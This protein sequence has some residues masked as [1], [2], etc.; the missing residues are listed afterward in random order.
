MQRGNQILPAYRVNRHRAGDTVQV[1]ALAVPHVRQILLIALVQPTGQKIESAAFEVDQANV[2]GP[3]TIT[4]DDQVPVII[5]APQLRNLF[6][7]YTSFSES[8]NLL[9][10]VIRSDPQRFIE[11]QTTDLIN[12]AIATIVQWLDAQLRGRSADEAATRARSFAEKFGVRDISPDCFKGGVIRTQC[13]AIEMVTSRDFFMPSSGVLDEVSAQGRSQDLSGF[14]VNNLRVISQARDYLS[15]RFRDQYEFA[16]SFARPLNEGMSVQLF[17]PVRNRMGSTKTAY[18]YVP[19]W[20]SGPIPQWLT[21][22]G[23]A[24]CLYAG[25]ARVMIEGRLPLA[26]YWHSFRITLSDPVDGGVLG[27]VDDVGFN[28]TREEIVFQPPR[29]DPQRW[30]RSQQVLVQ[31]SGMFGFEPWADTSFLMDLPLRE[32]RAEH[33]QGLS[34]L[35]SG[36]QADLV[37]QAPARSA[38]LQSTRLVLPDGRWVPSASAQPEHFQVDLSDLPAGTASFSLLQV[39]FPEVT[40]TWPVLSAEPTF[41]RAPGPNPLL[42]IPSAQAWQWSIA[43]DDMWMSD[44]SAF[45]LRL[46]ALP[47]LVLRQQS[48]ALQWRVTTTSGALQSAQTVALMLDMRQQELRTREPVRMSQVHWPGIINPI[49]YRVLDAQSRPLSPWQALGK[50]VITLPIL[51]KWSCHVDGTRWRVAGDR[52]ELIRSVEWLD[53][54]AANQSPDLKPAVFQACPD[55]LCLTV[56]PPAAG[57]RLGVQ[58]HW[59]DQKTFDLAAPATS[60]CP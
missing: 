19:G 42:V 52:L 37:L 49:E 7:L 36:S 30:P 24:G 51:Q 8:E 16:P 50:T 1:S 2:T 54:G 56:E 46:K 23:F 14:L 6:G 17:S 59:V 13:I 35:K 3:V 20:F 25:R 57:Q 21:N 32:L 11:L 4:S 45:S 22:D 44:D 41:T 5:L 34:G 26:P 29:L 33:I 58:L 40:L 10:E 31:L 38:C 39:G 15:N 43:L 12:R 48:H 28:P 9:K 18:V 55:G 47:P 60:P 53:A 27:H